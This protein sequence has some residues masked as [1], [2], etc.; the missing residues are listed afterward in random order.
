MKGGMFVL[1]ALMLPVI[2]ALSPMQGSV[3]TSDNA[4]V[5]NYYNEK[6]DLL[7]S[8]SS[9]NGSHEYVIKTTYP[10][11]LLYRE[12]L[13][14]V[15]TGKA[16]D[17]NT[18]AAVKCISRRV[19]VRV[20]ELI[21]NGFTDSSLVKDNVIE[22]M[23]RDQLLAMRQWIGDDGMGGTQPSNNREWS[24]VINFQKN[25][26]NVKKG[27][28]ALACTPEV[29]AVIDSVGLAEFHSHP[30]GT[31]TRKSDGAPCFFMQAP[32]QRDIS[33]LKSRI[34]FVFGMK[35]GLIYIYDKEGV[36]ATL[37]LKKYPRPLM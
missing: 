35:S 1:P 27:K 37:P 26:V 3:Q 6:G 4:G 13:T 11:N 34:G 32:S 23:P 31:D 18:P 25:L 29:N 7:R 21:R 30:S 10:R 24:G 22:T 19:A 15:R 36:R 28:V 2:M 14:S 5:S 17:H 33:E 9:T 20:E 16:G 8:V 12:E